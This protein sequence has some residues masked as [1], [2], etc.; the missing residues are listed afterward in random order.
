M[1][2]IGSVA[3]SVVGVLLTAGVTGWALRGVRANAARAPRPDA[4]GAFTLRYGAGIRVVGVFALAFA[5]LLLAIGLVAPPRGS[6]RVPWALL[7]LA[8]GGGAVW[9]LLAAW[10]EYVVV[11]PAGLRWQPVW[12]RVRELAWED[13]E[14]VRFSSSLGY[15]YLE[16]ATGRV[17]ASAILQGADLLWGEIGRRLPRESWAAAREQFDEYLRANY[18]HARKTRVEAAGASFG[19]ESAWLAI[20]SADTGRVVHALGLRDTRRAAPP[21]GIPA[22]LEGGDRVFVT[23]PVRGWTLC[24]GSGLARY[25]EGDAG[26]PPAFPELVTRLAARLGCDVH[27]FVTYR[28]A[29]LHG[30]ARATEGTLRRAFLW[31]GASGRT[32]ADVGKLTRDERALWF[33]APPHRRDPHADPDAS[34]VAGEREVMQLAGRWS[35]DPTTLSISD[36]GRLGSLAPPHARPDAPAT[37]R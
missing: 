36:P 30:W 10:R 1:P 3:L 14:R 26:S 15:L 31:D 34:W 9:V 18:G 13:V 11:G 37:P 27:Y 2:S 33:F 16:G 35:L 20:R 23:R 21:R 7:V 28:A 4:T 29:Q 24:V 17:R 32:L 22:A 6:Q 12:G 19:P 5:A 8:F 25:A